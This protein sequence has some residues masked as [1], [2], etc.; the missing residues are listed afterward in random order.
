LLLFSV[1]QFHLRKFKKNNATVA[2]VFRSLVNK[3][4]NKVFFYYKDQT[5]TFRDLDEFSNKVAQIFK[6]NGF[7]RGDEVSLLMESK[8][9]FVGIWLGLIKIGV[10]VA[11]LNI[12]QRNGPLV[13]SITSIKSK[14]IIYDSHLKSALVEVY[15]ILRS[16][17]D[18]KYFRY[19]PQRV[20]DIPAYDLNDLISK[21][22]SSS[23]Q[24]VDEGNFEGKNRLLVCSLKG[25]TKL[26]Q[27]IILNI[28][29]SAKQI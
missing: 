27:I 9:E 11:L 12:N 28:L 17:I 14:A 22:D 25:K 2:K 18:L 4:P 20:S 15:P 6:D 8:P 3:H 16:T 19:G 13:H 10:V 26:N 24:E 29:T 23:H 5:W 21:A 1:I 7:K